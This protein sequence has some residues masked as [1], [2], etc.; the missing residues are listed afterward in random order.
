MLFLESKV[1]VADNSGIRSVKCLKFLNGYSNNSK[2]TLGNIAVV[3][4][5]DYKGFKKKSSRK[6][7]LGVIVSLKKWVRRKTGFF[8][9]ASQNR[10]VLLDNKEKMLG[11]AV[12]GPVALELREQK[13]AKILFLSK[14][15]F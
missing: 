3:S 2:G 1:K 8:V 15:I 4:I 13:I 9:R 12:K 14:I 11:K 6:V 7:F 5:S 10:I